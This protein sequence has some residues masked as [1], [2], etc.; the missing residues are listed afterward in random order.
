MLKFCPKCNTQAY[1]DTSFFCFK[2]GTRLP[3]HIPEKK[4]NSSQ[5]YGIKGSDKEYKYTRD[6]ALFSPKPA[7]IHP[8]K[9]IEICA[10]CGDLIIDKNRIFCK[11]C[12]AYIQEIPSGDASS[13]VKHS[14]VESR[15][16]TPGVYQNPEIK[17]I[18]KQEPALMKESRLP[19]NLKADT[20]RSIVILVG[21]VI[22]FFSL[23]LTLLLMFQILR[24][25]Y[26][27]IP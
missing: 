11:N 4:N 12:G 18:K 7:S 21:F 3:V 13:I 8:I 6:A 9:P 23:I 5:S 10:Q 25:P 15:V 2:C 24:F 16:K 20:W 19:S 1:D 14:V 22:L 26:T 17:T 27:P